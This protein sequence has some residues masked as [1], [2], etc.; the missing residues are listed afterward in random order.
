[1]LGLSSL[2][3]STTPSLRFVD[4]VIAAGT[5]TPFRGVTLN[6]PTS[7]KVGHLAI[8]VCFN[9]EISGSTGATNSFSSA[10]ISIS[11]GNNLHGEVLSGFGQ[12]YLTQDDIT[13]GNIAIN[14]SLYNFGTRGLGM[15]CIFEGA[16]SSYIRSTASN[17]NAN[18]FNWGT[19]GLNRLVGIPASHAVLICQF[20]DD[21]ITTV[22]AY[23]TGF[24]LGRKAITAGSTN[25][26]GTG[27][28][29]VADHKSNINGAQSLTFA[30]SDVVVGYLIGV[31]P[32]NKGSGSSSDSEVVTVGN[33]SSKYTNAF[34]YLTGSFGS[35]NDGYFDMLGGAPI[36][37]LYY[38][39]AFGSSSMNFGLVGIH[40][41]NGWNMMT[42]GGVNY[43]RSAA[44]YTPNEFNTSWNFAATTN[45]FSTNGANVT[46]TFS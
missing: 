5:E 45:P 11:T 13:R 31:Q 32:L 18:G 21:D 10:H 27:A 4:S 29:C 40:P 25:N 35:I 2:L 39:N 28:I 46:V 36:S 1:M 38:N 12:K 41:N 43:M 42:V 34:G 16:S 26:G 33:L 9:D 20:L 14:T 22:S 24:T 3:T 23:P 15:L 37:G 7:A 30:L 44:T 17:G 8:V 19:G 6:I